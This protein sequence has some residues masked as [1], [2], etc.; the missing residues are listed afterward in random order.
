VTIDGQEGEVM[1][2]A[3]TTQAKAGSGGVL[4]CEFDGRVL[5]IW[6]SPSQRYLVENLV[7]QK[8]K[9]EK[10]GGVTLFVVPDRASRVELYFE[11]EHV[12][13]MEALV[14]ALKSA[15]MRTG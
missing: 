14:A 6:S 4:L 2:M 3:T 7:L 9:D 10:D 8:R 1:I 13:N 11:P 12:A 5:E 15:G